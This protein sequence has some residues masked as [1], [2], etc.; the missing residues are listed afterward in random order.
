MK[1][2]VDV[3]AGKMTIGEIVNNI[4]HYIAKSPKRLIID[5]RR[6]DGKN[7]GY[8]TTI[9]LTVKDFNEKC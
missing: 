3:C 6:R 9:Y 2:F 5:I 4:I 7:G 8:F 1:G